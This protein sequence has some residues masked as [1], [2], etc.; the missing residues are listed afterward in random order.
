MHEV[1][2]QKIGLVALALVPHRAWNSQSTLI[3][4]CALLFCLVS[5]GE[6]LAGLPFRTVLDEPLMDYFVYLIYRLLTG[7]LAALPLPVVFCAGKFLGLLG[8][9]LAGS[10]RRL[11]IHNLTIAF[12]DEKTA[13]EIRALARHHFS[14][15]GANLLSSIK[16]AAMSR[17]AVNARTRWENLEIL[18][19]ALDK[20]GMIGVISHIGNW[21]LFAQMPEYLP[22]HRFSTIYQK[23]G[24]PYIDANVRKSRARL[25]V[26]PFERKEGFNGPIKFIREGGGL[27]MLVDQHAGDG[28]LWTP[29]FNRLASTSPLAATLAIRTGAQVV[30]VAVYTDGLARWRF[31]V[32]EPVRSG[33]NSIESLTAEINQAL[34]RQIRVSPQDWFWVHN[35]WKTPEPKFLLKSYKRGIQYPENFDPA[36]LKPFR[37]L[38]RS[39]NWLGDAVMTVPAVRAIKQGRPDAHVTILTRAKLADFWKL[40]P[41]VDEVISI[42]AGDNIFRVAKKISSGF[43]VAILFPNSIR[44]ALEAWLA[45]IP[46]RVGFH[47]KG[48][49]ALLNQFVRKGKKVIAPEHQVNHYLRLATSIGALNSPDANPEKSFKGLRISN[50]ETQSEPRIPFRIGLCPGADYGPAKRWLPE[51][52]AEVIRTVNQRREC[53]WV[54]FGTKN[55]QPVGEQILNTPVTPG[56]KEWAHDP[57]TQTEHPTDG[58]SGFKNCHNLIGKTTLSELITELSRCQLL[59]TNDTGTMHLA[60]FLG[61]PTVSIFGS[62]EPALTGPMGNGHRVI[63]HHVACSPCF[64]REC[65]ID[66][67]CMKAVQ[68]DEVVE[69]VLRA[70]DE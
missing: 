15:L 40:V 42:E 11:V 22:Q 57:D 67:R 64:L 9:F 48:R 49:N 43:E 5:R 62:T 13:K 60:A 24:N 61:V 12:G 25:G 58:S 59:L 36:K 30:P 4:W 14:N 19:G 8:C 1:A 68:V 16:L 10:Y 69:A 33:L 63:R 31:V 35:R 70:L 2:L 17:E 27:A 6:K 50:P 56:Q 45:G 47:A 34:E 46:R 29:L 38:I 53:E 52:Y 32:S 55:D 21:E 41:E 39:S 26:E 44:S 54:L 66:F 65:P 28:G 37:M 18:S 51:R 7:F 3:S 23:L 20:G